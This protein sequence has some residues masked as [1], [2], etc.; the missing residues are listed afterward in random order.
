MYFVSVKWLIF[1]YFAGKGMVKNR[2]SGYVYRIVNT[3]NE[4]RYIGSTKRPN[5]RKREHFSQLRDG[6]HH[7]AQLQLAYNKYGIE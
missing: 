2:M 6:L 7:C 4:K 3:E 5:V 1:K